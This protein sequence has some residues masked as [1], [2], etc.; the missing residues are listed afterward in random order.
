MNFNDLDLNEKFAMILLNRQNIKR[1]RDDFIAI[2]A[3]ITLFGLALVGMVFV[4]YEIT[5]Q[6]GISI[7]P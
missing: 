4:L 1:M 3:L 5:G 7:F 6:L 2:T